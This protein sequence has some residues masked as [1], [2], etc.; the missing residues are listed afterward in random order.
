[1][2]STH[3]TNAYGV[4]YSPSLI[5]SFIF[6]LSSSCRI[7]SRLISGIWLTVCCGILFSIW[8]P[9]IYKIYFRR[10]CAIILGL[11][12]EKVNK[13]FIVIKPVVKIKC[14]TWYT[15]IYY[16]INTV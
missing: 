6:F 14:G 5:E 10:V 3:P 4:L 2:K 12:G 9:I 8:S 11:A 7:K 1:M 13:K 15:F 16:V